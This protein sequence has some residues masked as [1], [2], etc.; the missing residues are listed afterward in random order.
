M[1]NEI[2]YNNIPS[3]ASGIWNLDWNWLDRSGNWNDGSLTDISWLKSEKWYTKEVWYFNWGSSSDSIWPNSADFSSWLYI[4]WWIKQASSWSSHS[5]MISQWATWDDNHMK[6]KLWDGQ[7]YFNLKIDW[8]NYSTSTS[9]NVVEDDKIHFMEWIYNWGDI[10]LY[11]DNE[12]IETVNTSWTLWAFVDRWYIWAYYTWDFWND[13]KWEIGLVKLYN[14]TLSSSE[15]QALYIEWQR[16]FWNTPSYPTLLSWL[17]G[18]WDFRNGCLSNLVDW[19]LATNNWATLVTDHLG[20]KDS[21]RS[22]DG[23]DDNIKTPTDEPKNLTNWT[24]WILFKTTDSWQQV[25]FS[26]N[27]AWKQHDLNME[28]NRTSWELYL[29][30]DNWDANLVLQPTFDITDW[31]NR[32][33]V[34]TY[35]GD[36]FTAY[37]E[38]NQIATKTW[39]WY[40]II[41]SGKEWEWGSDRDD[42]YF[43]W[44][45]SLTFI[46][47]RAMSSNEVKNIDKLLFQDYIY[48][49][50]KSSTLNLQDWLVLNLDGSGKD[51]SGNGND[52]VLSSVTKVRR[53]QTE[54][55]KV[56]WGNWLISNP[57]DI[58]TGDLSISFKLKLNSIPS[59]YSWVVWNRDNND[60]VTWPVWAIRIVKDTWAI[61]IKNWGDTTYNITSTQ[62]LNVWELYDIKTTKSWTTWYLYINWVLEAS[63]TVNE[64][65][66][67]SWED[68]RM[69]DDPNSTYYDVFNWEMYGL[70]VHTRK[71]SIE[72]IQ[73]E[74]YLTYI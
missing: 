12:L 34:V 37:I 2:I 72:E 57:Y 29:D 4:C 55:M 27:Q 28:L 16:L 70:K 9:L 24:I 6:L 65:L 53:N 21:A 13:Y 60:W 17:V 52:A 54:G 67:T 66:W 15:R 20:N 23:V 46:L 56:N 7:V 25:L 3:W 39:S 50:S 36:N 8:S 62:T 47:N 35:D 11:I 26:K 69:F 45:I 1:S 48:P 10:K 5:A 63:W 18:Y 73:S 49:F 64:D 44:D 33:L 32:L 31:I 51:L 38:G 19:T 68:W 22:F 74:N 41:S 59:E 61:E 30:V 43:D 42:V 40:E 71:L 58:W 14:K